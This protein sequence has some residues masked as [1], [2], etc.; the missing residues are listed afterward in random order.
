MHLE[1][2]VLFSVVIKLEGG[3]DEDLRILDMADAD[4]TYASLASSAAAAALAAPHSSAGR[5]KDGEKGD[6]DGTTDQ[7][8]RGNRSPNS[9]SKGDVDD[10]KMDKVFNAC[11]IS[12]VSNYIIVIHNL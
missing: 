9:K 6:G 5:E 2:F 7:S 11:S 10:N 8:G 4:I 3:S 12:A 1:Y